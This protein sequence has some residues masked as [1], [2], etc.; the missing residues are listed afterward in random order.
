[1][2]KVLVLC[3][4]NSI[5]SQMAEAYLKFYAQGYGIFFSA[6]MPKK[7]I[8]PY[9]IQVMK[10]DNIDLNEHIS[11]TAEAF[12]NIHIDYLITISNHTEMPPPNNFTFTNHIHFII[13]DPVQM[14]DSK[15]I[16]GASS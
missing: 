7:A 5:L 15:D 14:N 3:S 4:A 10:E 9:A 2:K 12:N 6:G 1:M 16:N 8:D 13:Q 11:K